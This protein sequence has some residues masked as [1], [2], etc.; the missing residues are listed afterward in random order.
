[1]VEAPRELPAKLAPHIEEKMKEYATLLAKAVPLRGVTRIDFLSN[2]E[3]ELYVNEVNTIPG[4]LSKYLFIEPPLPFTQLLE[5]LISEALAAPTYT[6]NAI[7]ADG[8][9]L[10]SAS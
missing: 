7:G 10:N 4:S 2:G 5:D 3:D 6:P 1:M 9:A 8:T